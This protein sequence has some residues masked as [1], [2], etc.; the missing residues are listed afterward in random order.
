MPSKLSIAAPPTDLAG[1]TGD[2]ATPAQQPGWFA[3]LAP[4]PYFYFHF[5]KQVVL[6]SR[7]ARRGLYDGERWYASSAAVLHALERTGA[8]I[9]ITGLP[10]LHQFDGPCVFV[11]NHMSTLETI[12]LPG[13]IQPH[14]DVTFVVKRSL[15]E[16]PIFNH[17]ILARDPIIVDRVNPREDL[18]R[19]LTQGAELL[20]RGRSIVV[21]PQTTRTTV[22]DPSQFNTI[23]IKL[24]RDAQVPIVPVAVRSDA[25][26]NGRWL[27]EFGR[28][29][30][31]LPVKFAFGAP[32]TVQGRGTATHQAVIRFITSH[33]T[34]WGCEVVQPDPAQAESSA[35]ANP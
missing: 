14:K 5:I 8:H 20:G 2:Y 10:M 24:A 9:Q 33:L 3:R 32:L 27:K 11:A 12:F 29:D 21:F 16:Y 30:P 17:V 26:G 15:A 6:S 7:L 19:V 4:S 13:I 23:G 35:A 25:W 18:A 34:R 31:A 22:F 28:I 1:L